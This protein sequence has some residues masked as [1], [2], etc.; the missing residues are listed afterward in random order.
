MITK[1]ELLKA[2]DII[3]KYKEQQ[4]QIIKE[5]E[6]KEDQRSILILG[7]K[8]REVNCLKSAEIETIGDLL[9]IDRRDLRRI[10]NLGDKGINDINQ[11]LKE[12]GVSTTE[13]FT[14]RRHN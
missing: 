3:E 11:K 5:L 12:A 7:L 14:H 4:K 10:R 6:V 9:S 2:F 1:D 8:T 13:F